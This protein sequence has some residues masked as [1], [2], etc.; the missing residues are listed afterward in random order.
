[1]KAV[2]S[3]TFRPDDDAA[4]M[5]PPAPSG[6]FWL[7]GIGAFLI[8]WNVCSGLLTIFAA[9]LLLTEDTDRCPVSARRCAS[10]PRLWRWTAYGVVGALFVFCTG[11]AV[12]WIVCAA[13][14]ETMQALTPVD[15]WDYPDTVVAIVVGYALFVPAV[16]LIPMVWTSFAGE[17]RND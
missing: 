16:V 7:W 11:L 5:S 2:C 9:T 10:K 3:R 1:V 13:H 17:K 12:F 14:T 8:A 6:E 15:L 4:N